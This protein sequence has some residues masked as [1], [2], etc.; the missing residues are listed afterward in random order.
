V[1]LQYIRSAACC[2]DGSRAESRAEQRVGGASLKVRFNSKIHI[3]SDPDL[4]DL[5]SD[6]GLID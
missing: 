5:R 1:L 2:A 6:H 3:G 4:S